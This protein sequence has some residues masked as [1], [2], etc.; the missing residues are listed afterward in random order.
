MKKKKRKKCWM[1]EISTFYIH[2]CYEPFS[3]QF[4]ISTLEY[5]NT[6]TSLNE[7]KH[8]KMIIV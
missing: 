3:I 5:P 7:H 4:E 1:V 8:G 6:D 2:L